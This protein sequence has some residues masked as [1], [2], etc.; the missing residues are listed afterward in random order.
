[1]ALRWRLAKYRPPLA[2]VIPAI[3]TSGAP[4]PPN[5]SAWEHVATEG[6]PHPRV[7]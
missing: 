5:L 3:T 7:A 4:A 6:R 1:M 2:E